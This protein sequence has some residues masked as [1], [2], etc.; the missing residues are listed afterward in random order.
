MKYRIYFGL[1]F[2]LLSHLS[3]SQ[4]IATYTIRSNLVCGNDNSLVV[5]SGSQIPEL[6][7]HKIKLLSLLSH[8]HSQKTLQKIVFQIDQ[9]DTQGRYSLGENNAEKNS[10]VNEDTDSALNTF[11]DNDELVFRKKD[12]NKRIDYSSKWLKRHSLIELEI[13]ID[14]GESEPVNSSKWLYIDVNSDNSE[15]ELDRNKSLTY[16]HDKD[17]VSSSIYKIGFSEDH[18]FLLDSF[19][20]RLPNQA[21]WGS[22]ITDTMKIRHTGRFFGLNFKRTQDDY[23]SQLIAVKVGPLRI[24]RRTENR[25]KVF[26]KLKSPALFIDYVMMPNG[27]VMDTMI[28]IPFKISLFFSDLATIT[29]MDWNYSADSSDLAVRASKEYPA[30]PVNGI[31]SKDKKVFNQITGNTFSLSSRMGDFNVRLDIPADFPIQSNLYLRD[32]LDDIDPPE[33]YPGQFGNIGFKTTGW[34]NVDSEL[35]HLNFTVCVTAAQ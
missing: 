24:I 13:I 27:F 15:A 8:A 9:K 2:L 21:A 30:M 3:Y 20:W 25:I 18:P 12:L 7:G 31:A 19:Q 6:S 35:Y 4:I 33:N 28:D 26:W 17:S 16:E 11:T 1:C 23:Y 14:S 5:I 22:D 29:T 34:E 32:A 10:Q